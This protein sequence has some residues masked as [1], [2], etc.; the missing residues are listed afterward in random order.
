VR[1]GGRHLAVQLCRA[2]G[3]AA[4]SA[5]HLVADTQ[6]AS[7]SALDWPTQ[8]D[9]LT[10]NRRQ[11][12]GWGREKIVPASGHWRTATAVS[13]SLNRPS[14]VP[15]GRPVRAFALKTPGQAGKGSGRL[16]Q[17]HD[18]GGVRTHG[19]GALSIWKRG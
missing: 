10:T 3:R 12:A 15:L 2:A 16:E 9:D 8:S 19:P 6:A 18:T 14:K 13:C 5:P 1:L 7:A 11:R 17:T 4:I